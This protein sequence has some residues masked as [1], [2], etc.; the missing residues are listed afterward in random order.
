MMAQKEKSILVSIFS[1]SISR[2]TYYHYFIDNTTTLKFIKY[3]NNI[4]SN[5]A[6][7]YPNYNQYIFLS[8]LCLYDK[9]FTLEINK[10][11]IKSDHQEN[12][13]YP[14][15]NDSNNFYQF[16]IAL[17][18]TQFLHYANNGYGIQDLYNFII[19][20][21]GVPKIPLLKCI[22][23]KSVKQQT[24]KYVYEDE[25]CVFGKFIHRL[26]PSYDS[27]MYLNKNNNKIYNIANN[28]LGHIVETKENTKIITVQWQDDIGTTNE[29]RF[30][31]FTSE[32]ESF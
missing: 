12:I 25:S 27:F 18:K 3:D 10:L 22:S 21:N 9:E 5:I 17:K 13:Y 31:D 28:I 1:D 29:Y 20:K 26:N 16:S 24:D 8:P 14:H 15:N 23:I 2:D 7:S 11:N 30:N 32:Y 19:G 4:L 6:S